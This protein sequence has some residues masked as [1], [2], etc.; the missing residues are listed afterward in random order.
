MSTIESHHAPV[1]AETARSAAWKA[2]VSRAQRT[3]RRS[4]SGAIVNSALV[5]SLV[6]MPV[7]SRL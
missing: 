5:H 6:R 2:M 7:T 3:A 1:A 4:T